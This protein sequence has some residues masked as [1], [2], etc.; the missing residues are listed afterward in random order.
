MTNCNK[1]VD[2]FIGIYPAF[3]DIEISQNTIQSLSGTGIYMAGVYNTHTTGSTGGSLEESHYWMR[4][5]RADGCDARLFRLGI[6]LGRC[7]EFRGWHLVDWKSDDSPSCLRCTNGL[8]L[9]QQYQYFESLIQPSVGIAI[10]RI[11]LRDRSSEPGSGCLISRITPTIFNCE[12]E[13]AFEEIGPRAAVTRFTLLRTGL[14]ARFFGAQV[15]R[16]VR[17]LNTLAAGLCCHCFESGWACQHPA[18]C[19]NSL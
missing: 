7:N 13:T 18:S 14:L 1:V 19:L 8:R 10:G 11:G 15:F 2:N 9:E 12:L 4:A 3:Q 16:N 17:T 5:R 6:D